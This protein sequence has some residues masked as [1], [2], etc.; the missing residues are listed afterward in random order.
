MFKY[1]LSDWLCGLSVRLVGGAGE[2]GS[3]CSTEGK[4]DRT[5]GHYLF[6]PAGGAGEDPAGGTA[7]E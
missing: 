5:T 1:P 4:P 3:S 6:F 2:S 7:G